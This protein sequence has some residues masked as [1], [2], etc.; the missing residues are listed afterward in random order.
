MSPQKKHVFLAASGT[1]YGS[2]S[3]SVRSRM[4]AGSYSCCS[5]LSPPS[6][7]MESLRLPCGWLAPPP[8]DPKLT[9]SL[10]SDAAREKEFRRPV[11]SSAGGSAS[12]CCA[13]C[14]APRLLKEP[15]RCSRPLP[16]PALD[17]REPRPDGAG[18][19]AAVALASVDG[20]LA[21]PC[22]CCCSR[23]G[24]TQLVVHVL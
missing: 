22:C 18:A 24:S 2:T 11:F 4:V 23:R 12:S 15:A 19:G 1:K 13:A 14:S 10:S 16:L 17:S 5:L 6:T 3:S 7:V 21:P 20:G 9:V 8:M